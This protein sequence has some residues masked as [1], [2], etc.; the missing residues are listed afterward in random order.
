MNAVIQEFRDKSDP[1]QAG[2]PCEPCLLDNSP[3]DCAGETVS[4]PPTQSST[5]V[6]CE[7]FGQSL[8]LPAYK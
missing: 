8:C 2:I 5:I 7:D 1:T 3:E 6:V 4:N